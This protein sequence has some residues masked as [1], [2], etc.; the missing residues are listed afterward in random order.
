MIVLG[1]NV[2]LSA[3]TCESDD[4]IPFKGTSPFTLM[5]EITVDPQGGPQTVEQLENS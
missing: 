2:K 4:E 1:E 5:G 3:F